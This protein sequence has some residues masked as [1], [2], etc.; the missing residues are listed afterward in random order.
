MEKIYDVNNNF[1]QKDERFIDVGDSLEC[2][3]GIFII[4]NSFGT[5]MDCISPTY[6]AICAAAQSA[7]CAINGVDYDP[8]TDL[9]ME[10][11]YFSK[12]GHPY[13]NPETKG[14]FWEVDN[15]ADH[16]I[17][18]RYK[19]RNYHCHFETRR[20]IPVKLFNGKKEGDIVTI[21]LPLTMVDDETGEVMKQNATLHLE[22]SQSTTRYRRFGNFEDVKARL[23]ESY[24]PSNYGRSDD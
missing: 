24:S 10:A 15:L 23:E 8:E 14:I 7:I 22:L 5:A 11:W 13:N 2:A 16:G 17:Y 12:V 1:V 21:I 20:S 4:P 3:G 9:I 18:L 6:Q 19:G